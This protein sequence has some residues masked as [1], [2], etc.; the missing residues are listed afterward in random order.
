MERPFVWIDLQAAKRKVVQLKQY[1]N[2]SRTGNAEFQGNIEAWTLFRIDS[3][4]K[5]WKARGSEL[6][7]IGRG[8]LGKSRINLTSHK[9]NPELFLIVETSQSKSG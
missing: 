9:P 6:H 8:N 7:E 3:S 1:E 5:G 4:A 2:S